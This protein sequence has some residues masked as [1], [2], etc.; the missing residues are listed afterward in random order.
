MDKLD[1][2]IREKHAELQG[3]QAELNE[4]LTGIESPDYETAGRLQQVIDGLMA[5]IGRLK[6]LRMVQP[7]TQDFPTWLSRLLTDDTV[8]TLE[9]W[10]RIKDYESDTST[11]MLEIRKGKT[12]HRISCTLRLTEPT[13][14]HLHRDYTVAD[15]QH[16]GWKAGR[17]TRT[18]YFKT[19]LRS[20]D[21]FDAFCQMMS[22][23]MLEALASLWGHGEQ[24]YRFK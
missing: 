4:A 2:I 8:T 20:P 9:L 3:L 15:L 18:F 23:T 1:L 12:G 7:A 6:K 10:T 17:G 19:R 24:Y 14:A 11:R 5:E 22:V 21:A 16:I 13:D